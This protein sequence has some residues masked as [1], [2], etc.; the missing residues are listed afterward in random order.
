MNLGVT[1]PEQLWVYLGYPSYPKTSCIS[2]LV[3]PQCKAT[4]HWAWE[5]KEDEEEE[6]GRAI[7]VDAKG[8]CQG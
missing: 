4:A 5:E 3:Q 8:L 6:E 1:A 2:A 7:S